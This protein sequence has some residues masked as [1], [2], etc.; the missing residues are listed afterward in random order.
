[1]MRKGRSKWLVVDNR[2]AIVKSRIVGLNLE[3]SPQKS[4]FFRKELQTTWFMFEYS[5]GGYRW[6]VKRSF[7]SIKDFHAYLHK[8]PDLSRGRSM[9]TVS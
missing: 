6:T 4:Y 1:M 3:G 7:E 8:D 5:I 2:Q 9:L